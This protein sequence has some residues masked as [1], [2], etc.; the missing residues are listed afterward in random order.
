MKNLM[1]DLIGILGLSSFG[2][3]LYLAQGTATTCMV[4]GAILISYAMALAARGM[5]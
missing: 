5:R 3:G 2:Y 4:I 1:A